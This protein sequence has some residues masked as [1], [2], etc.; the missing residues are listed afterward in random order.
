[1]DS[2]DRLGLQDNPLSEI[3][4][5]TYIPELETRGVEVSY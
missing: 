4:I 2:G 3:S 5:N 1:M